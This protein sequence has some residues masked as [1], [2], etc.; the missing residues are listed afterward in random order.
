M[1][2]IQVKWLSQC[3]SFD[4]GMVFRIPGES[5][6][7][8]LHIKLDQLFIFNSIYTVHYYMLSA[9]IDCFYLIKSIS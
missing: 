1:L 7:L 6:Y 8:N 3:L 2:Q 5:T 9:L 4:S